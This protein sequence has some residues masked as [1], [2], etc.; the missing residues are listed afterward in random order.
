MKNRSRGGGDLKVV[1]MG[2]ATNLSDDKRQWLF[3]VG[4]AAVALTRGSTNSEQKTSGRM[5]G[6]AWLTPVTSQILTLRLGYFFTQPMPGPPGVYEAESSP[7]ISAKPVGIV[8]VSQRLIPTGA[9]SSARIASGWRAKKGEVL[10]S[11]DKLC[12]AREFRLSP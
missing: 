1:R 3:L 9:D 12:S 6:L 10:A 7:T 4:I 2:W 8:A 11:N 5:S